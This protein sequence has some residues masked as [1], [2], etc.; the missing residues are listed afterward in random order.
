MKLKNLFLIYKNGE[1]LM[2]FPVVFGAEGC[3]PVHS[4]LCFLFT[5]C[6]N[7][8]ISTWLNMGAEIAVGFFLKKKKANKKPPLIKPRA[9]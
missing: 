5:E 8:K 1:K 6:L 9:F 4:T 2:C 7:H 3:L